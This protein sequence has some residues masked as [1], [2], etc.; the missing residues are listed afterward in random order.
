VNSEFTLWVRRPWEHTPFR[1]FTGQAYEQR[2]AIDD[3]TPQDEEYIEAE[4]C[5]FK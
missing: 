5:A 1:V 2:L 4:D 3:M